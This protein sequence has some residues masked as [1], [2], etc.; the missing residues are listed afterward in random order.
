MELSRIALLILASG[1]NAKE[2]R[3][4]AELDDAG[5]MTPITDPAAGAAGSAGTGAVSGNAGGSPALGGTAGGAFAGGTGGTAGTPLQGS[6]EWIRQET[7]PTAVFLASPL[8]SPELA[9]R[10]GR[11]V[12]RWSNAARPA[13][14]P[15]R[16]RAERI[17]LARR[18]LPDWLRAYGVDY[19]F[20]APGDF[21]SRRVES[22][23]SL[24]SLPG[25]GLQY[26][27]EWR[28]HIYEV[29]P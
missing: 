21:R 2:A 24:R 4:T 9:V 12:L 20:A 17:L 23:E 29:L 27:D 14:E 10:T 3:E 7:P 6:M 28:F 22:P 16:V 25:L 11:R 13:D 5:A 1:C 19:V 26:S 8:Y 18:P 15:R